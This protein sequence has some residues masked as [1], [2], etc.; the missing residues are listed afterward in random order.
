MLIRLATEVD[1]CVLEIERGKKSEREREKSLIERFVDY[2]DQLFKPKTVSDD[3]ELSFSENQIL[4][5]Y[6]NFRLLLL[7]AV[8]IFTEWS[9]FVVE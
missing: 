2:S 7:S 3:F 4:I 1:V 8:H 5:L 6:M 9:P